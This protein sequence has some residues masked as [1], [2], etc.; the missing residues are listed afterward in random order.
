MMSSV[1]AEPIF[2]MLMRTA[3]L[4][5]T[6]TMLVCGR[7]AVADV[8]HVA[9]IDDGAVDG[10][11]G[12]VV[13]V[14]DDGRR[15]IGFDG[16]FEAVDLHGAGRHDDVLRGDGVDD[17]DGRKPLG[18]EGLQIEVDLNLALLA[19]IGEG[20]YGALDGGEWHADGVLADVQAAAR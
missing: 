11:D 6:R 8:G 16:V 18:L 15:G 2:M 4:P 3:R 19:A 7:I 20:E 5:S 1:E 12:Q 10:F 17:I 9:D 14:V 13:Q